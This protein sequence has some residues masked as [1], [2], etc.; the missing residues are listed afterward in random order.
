[1]EDH[2]GKEPGHKKRAVIF[3]NAP[4]P[5]EPFI[6]RYLQ[7]DDL[8]ICADGGANRIT[9]YDIRPHYI[10]GDLD[11]ASLETLSEM[12]DVKIIRIPE[13]ETTD[14]FK[15]L[16]FAENHGAEKVVVFGATGARPDHFL[17]NISLLGA[18]KD[19]LDVQL[20]DEWCTILLITH[21][22]IIRG[23]PGQTISLWPLAGEAAGVVTAGLKF[24]LNGDT[25]YQDTRGISN[26]LSEETATIKISSGA[27]LAI[28]Q[29]PGTDS[30]T[31]FEPLIIPENPG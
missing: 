21:A 3:A 30:Y 28:V 13:Q 16:K 20:I 22:V 2:I 31:E 1:M 29:H 5:S 11:S 12:E 23:V 6:R 18:F 19:S 27:L 15:A 4:L 17:G 9:E 10:I 7:E 8:I 24:Q 25:L 26:E 14:L